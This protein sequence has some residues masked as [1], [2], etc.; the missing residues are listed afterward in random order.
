MKKV[1]L[2][3][4]GLFLA[5]CMLMMPILGGYAEEGIESDPIPMP[6]AP[7]SSE[8]EEETVT[9]DEPAGEPTA[10]PEVEDPSVADPTEAPRDEEPDAPEAEPTQEPE[11]EKTMAPHVTD[12]PPVVEE[13]SYVIEFGVL[14]MLKNMTVADLA[15]AIVAEKTV[16][17]V[18]IPA[19]IKLDGEGSIAQYVINNGTISGGTYTVFVENNGMIDG[20]SF[21]GIVNNY[22]TIKDGTFAGIVYN[23]EEQLEPVVNPDPNA[24][25]PPQPR[26]GSIVGGVFEKDSVLNNY[27]SIEKAEI[28]GTINAGYASRIAS[29]CTY[30][31]EVKAGTVHPGG[32]IMVKFNVANGQGEAAYGANV[33]DALE[34]LFGVEQGKDWYWYEKDIAAKKLVS[35]EDTFGFKVLNFVQEAAAP[36]ATP[37]P[38]PT[39]TQPATAAPTT[40]PTSTPRPTSAPTSSSGYGWENSVSGSNGEVEGE[41]AGWGDHDDLETELLDY[42]LRDGSLADLGIMTDD[43]GIKVA[44]ELV[45][46]PGNMEADIASD[47]E[48]ADVEVE[49]DDGLIPGEA[50]EDGSMPGMMFIR[51]KG[52]GTEARTLTLTLSQIKRMAEEREVEVLLFRNGSATVSLEVSELLEDKIP[53]LV[54]LMQAWAYNETDFAEYDLAQIDFDAIELATASTDE[55]LREVQLKLTIAPAIPV[56]YEIHTELWLGENCKEIGLLLDKM[57]IAMHAQTA[58]ENVAVYFTGENNDNSLLESHRGVV[59]GV[60]DVIDGYEVVFTDGAFTVLGLSRNVTENEFDGLCAAAGGVGTYYIGILP[61]AAEEQFGDS[62][63]E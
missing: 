4:M 1:F 10:A 3:W 57:G 16:N 19:G 63:A 28:N 31:A 37:T 61:D 50:G 54:S 49:V 40:K 32:L 51:A 35:A 13:K 20:G 47:V 53:K 12:V 30:G 33:L 6:E 39:A 55:E 56:G 52:I 5:L 15:A 25:V 17:T 9:P 38:V 43:Q 36:T 21:A 44:Y 29:N 7:V 34:K 14:T 62:T 23:G 48:A 60:T 22:G 27:W 8:S 2:K 11:A 42:Y 59:P 58:S 41:E 24:T 18:V 46:I 45:P 26:E